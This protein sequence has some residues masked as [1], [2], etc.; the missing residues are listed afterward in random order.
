LPEST[1]LFTAC[2]EYRRAGDLDEK[3]LPSVGDAGYPASVGPS[4]T[5]PVRITIHESADA[6]RITA[7]VADSVGA[8]RLG[9]FMETALARLLDAL[10][11]APDSALRNI[12]V[13][14]EAERH[15]VLYDW[16]ATEAAY[17][18]NQGVHQLFEEQAARNPEAVALI[19][20]DQSLTYAE[21][22]ARAN[23]LA[24]ALVRHG[25]GRDQPVA[26]GLE[27]SPELIV[28]VLGILKAGGACLPLD[29][30][31]PTERLT[32]IL[33]FS[34]AHLLVATPDTAARLTL[35][36]GM[37][38]FIDW[39]GL[40]VEPEQPPNVPVSPE[41]LA[42]CLYTSGSTGQPKGVAM[43]HRALLNLVVWQLAQ[44]GFDRPA[45]TLQPR[46]S[47]S[48]HRALG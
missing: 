30:S 10:E 3:M 22:N 27:R 33:A 44:P 42:Y 29:L 34:E 20:E 16:N 14:P 6:F 19:Y 13:L 41:Q 25:V 12:D 1:P 7:R 23:R 47:I 24:R 48:R 31:Y 37:G 5:Y 8:E 45:R 46:L 18:E 2:L 21:L 28:A 38:V 9:D 32:R 39:D 15:R 26:I 11:T 40:A 35:P 17:P 43:P 36:D 4:P